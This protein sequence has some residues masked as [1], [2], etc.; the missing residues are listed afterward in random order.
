[1]RTVFIGS[2][3]VHCRQVGYFLLVEEVEERGERYG[4]R[5][6]LGEEED[7]SILGITRSQLEI[8]T[9]ASRIMKARVTPVTLQDVVE[10]FLLR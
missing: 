9:L 3:H 10:D 8:L 2:R 5:V 1:M 7:R 4:L 6:T